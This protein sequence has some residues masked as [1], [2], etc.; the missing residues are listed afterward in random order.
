VA[1]PDTK[2]LP[3]YALTVGKGKPKLKETESGADTGCKFTL[4]GLE[5]QAGGGPVVHTAQRPI[6]TLVETCHNT[7]MA[8]FAEA[9]RNMPLANLG[10]Q[11]DPGTRPASKAP[12]ISPSNIPLR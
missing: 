6:I 7:T 4:Q 12:G 5:A 2:L 8:A 1:H 11:P 10:Q 3:T 9:M